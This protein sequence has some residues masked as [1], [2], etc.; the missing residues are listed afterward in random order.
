MADNIL[1]FASSGIPTALVAWVGFLFVLRGLNRIGMIIKLSRIVLLIVIW[2]MTT[3]AGMFGGP[4]AIKIIP[5]V[6][7][8]IL[9][10]GIFFFLMCLLLG[11]K[12]SQP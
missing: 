12:D 11:K 8:W 6:V 5:T 3:L 2:M 1:F 10:L 9:V 7:A 4:T